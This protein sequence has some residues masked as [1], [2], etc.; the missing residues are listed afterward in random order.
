M[1]KVSLKGGSHIGI[2][3]RR[4]FCTAFHGVG[5]CNPSAYVD[6]GFRCSRG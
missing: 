3:F 4:E 1:Q 2:L 5:V 6:L